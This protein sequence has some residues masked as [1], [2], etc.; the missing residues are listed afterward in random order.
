M[1]KETLKLALDALK[2][3]QHLVTDNEHHAYVMEY[4]A[5][6]EK[7]E[8]AL[9]KQEGQSNYCPNC[10]TLAREL[11]SIKQ[12]QGEPVAYDVRCDNCGGNGYDPK[13]NNYYCSSCEGSGFL[14][15]LLYTHHNNASRC[16][17]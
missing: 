5:I 10:E 9:A 4:N 3:N 6:I 2:D 16:Q 11:Q 7:L 17:T 15:K 14:E 1:S 12:E 8:E 13:N